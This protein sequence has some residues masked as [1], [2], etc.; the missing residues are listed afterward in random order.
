MGAAD[1]QGWALLALLGGF[2]GQLAVERWTWMRRIDQKL[3]HLVEAA[4]RQ[5]ERLKA[6][7]AR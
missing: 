5:D 7:E 3:D 6:L 4:A 1:G 2:L